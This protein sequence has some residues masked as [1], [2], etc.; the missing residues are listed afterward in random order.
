[1]NTKE[2]RIGDGLIAIGTSTISTGIYDTFFKNELSVYLDNRP[3][4]TFATF[5]I[6]SAAI[7]L[8]ERGTLSK[9]PSK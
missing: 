8:T 5:L 6:I 9:P 7:Y 4:T 3:L 1:M 2:S